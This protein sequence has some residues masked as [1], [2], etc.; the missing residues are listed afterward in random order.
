[1]YVLMVV[2]S[3]FPEGD[4]GAVRDMAFAKMY[5]ALGYQTILL[6][7]GKQ[8]KSGEFEGVQY[9]SLY[10]EKNNIWDHIVKY[11]GY[12]KRCVAYLQAIFQ[13]Y[14]MPSVIHMNDIPE[15]AIKYLVKLAKKKHITILHDSTEW[16]S[17]SEFSRG[18]WDKAY[19][20]KNRLN[21]TVIHS[22]IKV[23]AISQYLEEHFKSRGLSVIRIPV[24]LDVKR[25]L[26]A[27]AVEKEKIQMIYAGSPGQKDYLREIVLAIKALTKEEQEKL[28]IHIF[29]VDEKQLKEC[30]NIENVESCFS[31]YGRVS[32]EMVLHEM[33]HM[34]FSLLLRPAGERYA[35]AGFPTKVVEAMSHGVAMICNMSSDLGLY[36]KDGENA[37]CV[38]ECSA[39]S[40]VIALRKALAMRRDDID[41]LKNNARC[42][43][44]KSFDYRCYLE[45]MRQIIYNE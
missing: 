7:M 26:V 25:A 18:I 8:Q 16:Y 32:R 11:F 38:S 14:G 12:K 30:C 17:S 45:E 13:K 2:P 6:G 42:L 35:K 37:I 28:K 34:D 40:M 29:G 3:D 22:P 33:L 31:I 36:L 9:Y 27:N 24:I 15:G 43:A 44:E 21:T 41:K 10:Q 19:I 5:R 1:M 39:E 4:A 23:I 20:L